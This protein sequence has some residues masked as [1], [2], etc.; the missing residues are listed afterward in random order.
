M[1]KIMFVCLG[2]ICRSPMAEFVF[3]YLLNKNGLS[4]RF[5]IASSGTSSEEAGNDIHYG[6]KN[7]LR[8]MGIPFFH[9]AATKFT[10]H[11]Y[12]KYDYILVMEQSNI[13]G[14]LRII[15]EDKQNKIT[16]LKDYADGG[17]IADPWYTGNFDD[18]Y[19][20]VMSGCNAFLKFLKDRSVI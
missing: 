10:A 14:L 2:N 11:D 18:T 1:I 9:H 7:K 17:D 4:D 6:T 20:D 5:E 15:G 8:E 3:K 16:R 12:E 19:R 13:R